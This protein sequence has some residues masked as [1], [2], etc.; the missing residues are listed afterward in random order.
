MLHCNMTASLASLQNALEDIL[1][2]LRFSRRSGDLGRLAVVGCCEVRRWA[3]EAGI[4][5]LA[6][7][8]SA[9]LNNYPYASHDKFLAVI[10]E[11][12]VAVEEARLAVGMPSP[13]QME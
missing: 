1:A 12:I 10:D 13:A 11:L 3:R 9:L 4:E 6:R 2:D 5:E 7:H 8:S